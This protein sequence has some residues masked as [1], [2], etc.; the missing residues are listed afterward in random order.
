[1]RK[2]LLVAV[3]LVA[4]AIASC[5]PS[6]TTNTN[7]SNNVAAASPS[8]TLTPARGV[9][10]RRDDK[11]WAM[12]VAQDGTAEVE[13]GRLAAQKGQSPDVKR[14]GQRMV[15]DH[16]KAGAELK[17]IATKKSITLPTEVKAEHKEA[18]DRL[19]KLSGAEFDREYMSLMAQDHDKAV[20]AFQEESTGGA[21][22]ELKAFAT[23]TLPTLQEHQRLAHEIKDKLK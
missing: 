8:P 5:T 16:S 18:R 22:A 3:A 7:N 1:M 13:L 9:A 11:T 14:F 6:E 2:I 19:A 21:D 4:L 23:K 12:E 15:T 17:Q 10:P 20:S